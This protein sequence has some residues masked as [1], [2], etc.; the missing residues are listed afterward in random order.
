MTGDRTTESAIRRGFLLGEWRVLPPENRLVGPETE[1]HLEPKTM[2]LLVCLAERAGRVVSRDEIFDCV[3]PG[4]FVADVALKRTI[5][6]LRHALGDAP[7]QA[8]YIRTI[9]KRGYQLV[10]RVVPL[11]PPTERESP[12]PRTRKA[13][14]GP[15]P[16]RAVAVLPFDELSGD[17]EQAYF[18]DGMTDVLIS[19][20]ARIRALKVISRTSAMRYRGVKKPIP[21]TAKELGV[22]A[23]IEGA[24]LRAGQQVR[25]TAQ[26]VDAVRDRLLWSEAYKREVG[27]VLS[28]QIEI[29]RAIVASIE[30]ELTPQEHAHLER[31]DRPIDPAVHEA[32]L[33]GRYFWH[34]RT[35]ETV[36]Q[37]LR[38][39]EE[40]VRLDPSFAPAHAGIADSYIVDGGRY[41]EVP[42]NVAYGRARAAAL[43]AIELDETL[44]EAHTSLAAV[45]TD[46]DWDWQGADRE[47]LR[48]IEL[49]PN[50]ATAHSW[51]AEHLSRMGRHDE[52]VEEARRALELDP[53]SIFSSML[54][55]W[56]LFFARR[57]E[58]A[59]RQA[60]QT[61]DLDPD[62]ATALRILGWSYEES[63]RL[64]EAIEAHRRACEL[65]EH[66]PNFTAQLGRALAAAGRR[67]EARLVLD[68][69]SKAS[70][71]SYV[72]AFDIAL[73]H[74]ALE[75]RDRALEWLERAFDEHS[76]H[77]PYLGVNPRLDSLREESR[78]QDLLE[79]MGL[80]RD[81]D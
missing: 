1:L 28:L 81:Q 11:E 70:E 40:A 56:I 46:Y 5:S 49:N 7:Q 65:T 80:A 78:F 8:R 50:Y 52:A 37:G 58:E 64:E 6:T 61:L 63:G 73:I 68:R 67:A 39:F 29:A 35:A 44:A 57:Y 25:V 14:D 9:H 12:R 47:Y 33:K 53:V 21:V 38:W 4:A 34:K 19:N 43:R 62:Y 79:R 24:V 23:V 36:Q 13:A 59:I 77:L 10:E 75:D 72:S 30:L 15:R 45:M 51:Y 54:V 32:Y 66:R 76:D 17:P 3:W 71:H 22:D 41:L 16:I 55:A 27:D 26:L 18:A 60:R 74:A 20:L 69:L 48:S 42:P 31:A 2:D